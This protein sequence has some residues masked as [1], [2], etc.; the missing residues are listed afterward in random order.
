MMMYFVHLHQHQIAQKA[1]KEF[2]DANAQRVTVYS[3]PCTM[4][5]NIGNRRQLNIDRI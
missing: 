2:S 5:N 4:F 1:R 3:F